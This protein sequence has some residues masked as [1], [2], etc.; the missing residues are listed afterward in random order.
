MWPK[1]SQICSFL[2]AKNSFGGLRISRN[3]LEEVVCVAAD[4]FSSENYED[5][6][7]TIDQ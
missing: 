6:T 2:G 1:D 5:M 7:G 3:E 4:Y